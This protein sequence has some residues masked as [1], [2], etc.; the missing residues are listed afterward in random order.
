MQR[1]SIERVLRRAV[2]SPVVA[3]G[4]RAAVSG[5]LA[6]R[7]AV[8]ATVMALGIRAAVSGTLATRRAVR[9]PV[10]ALGLRAAVST[11]ARHGHTGS[12]TSRRQRDQSAGRWLREPRLHRSRP[13]PFSC[14]YTPLRR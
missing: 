8:R 4:I 9:A 12:G 3:L 10:M 2:R 13:L 11:E 7:R 1:L 5:T 6:T 14:T